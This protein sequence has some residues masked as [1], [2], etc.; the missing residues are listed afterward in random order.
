MR[1]LVTA[2]LPYLN[3]L[4]KGM[5][6]MVTLCLELNSWY[7]SFGTDMQ[8]GCGMN[9]IADRLASNVAEDINFMCTPDVRLLAAVVYK[10]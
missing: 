2:V 1:S 10:C 7:D 3:H 9:M 6:A 8:L 4:M 5:G